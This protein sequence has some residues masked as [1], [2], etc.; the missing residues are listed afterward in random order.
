MKNYGNINQNASRRGSIFGLCNN[1]LYDSVENFFV[2]PQNELSDHSK[3]VTYFKNN[4]VVKENPLDT[5]PWKKLNSKYKWDNEKRKIFSE[6]F[7]NYTE[8]LNEIS[9]RIDAGLIKSTGEKIQNLYKKVAEKVLKAKSKTP[10]KVCTNKKGNQKKWFDNEC[11]KAKSE[12][13]KAGRNKY[14]DPKD[15]LLRTKYH[16][17]LRE[18]KSK[19]KSKR[20]NFWQNK[21]NIL[22][23]SL[24]NSKKFWEN[25]KTTTEIKMDQPES[26][27]SGKK[28]FDHFS[29]LHTE[30]GDKPTPRIEIE[31][32]GE[33]NTELNKPF[34]KSEFF[35]IVNNLKN[36]KAVG[37]DSISNEMI[38]H[39][40]TAVLEILLK[41]I[42]VC[43]NKHLIPNSW[44]ND[45]I[46]VIFKDGDKND[47][48]NYRGICISSALLKIVCS[49]LN[50]RIQLHCEKFNLIDKNQIGFK[51]DH[52]TS[53]HLLTLKTL[54]KKTCYYW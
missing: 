15:N 26:K 13:R 50:K 52:R 6:T 19:C 48:N 53:D 38:K 29:K 5:Y 16:E 43:L 28:W 54:V 17:K 22:E 41:F 25:M 21:F 9:Q 27:I 1:I 14:N 10:S 39:T 36:E 30:K 33:F 7:T 31:D 46:N 3:I 45:L 4:I 44:C 37:Y 2:L 32:N 23:N 8:D 20:Y 12:V 18:Y 49:M 47:P 42:N 11:R 40:P 34:S 51:K 35:S 24:T